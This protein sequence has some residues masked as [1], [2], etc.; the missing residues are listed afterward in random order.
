MV[1]VRRTMC[2]LSMGCA[3]NDA[4]RAAADI[5]EDLGRIARAAAK[6]E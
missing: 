4:R 6:A 2:K 3:R 5:D 1:A